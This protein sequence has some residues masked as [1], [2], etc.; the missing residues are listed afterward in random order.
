ML[1]ATLTA[2]V[3]AKRHQACAGEAVALENVATRLIRSACG[4]AAALLGLSFSADGAS[5]Q[6][7]STFPL[8]RGAV[9]QLGGSSYQDVLTRPRPEYDPIGIHVRSFFVMPS[10][11]SKLLFDDNVF[12]AGSSK[13]SDWTLQTRPELLVR[14]DWSNHSLQMQFS[15][16]NFTHRTF[17]EEDH[18]DYSA[19]IDG[20]LD[21]LRTLNVTGAAAY[22]HATIERGTDDDL[23]GDVDQPIT[24]DQVEL[25]GFVNGAFSRLFASVGAKLRAS[26]YND[27]LIG[28]TEFDQDY[29][30]GT[31]T[32]GIS[33]LGYQL[34]PMTGIFVQGTY[35]VRRFRDSFYDS[36]GLRAVAGLAFE[37][38]R[39]IRGEVY[40]GYLQQ[41][42]AS[43][44][45]DDLMTWTYGARL[46]W[47]PTPLI[48]VSL[49]GKREAGQ[50][51]FSSGS[52]VIEN[53]ANLRVDYEFRRNVI[54]SG[55][56]GYQVEDYQAS[57][58]DTS[59]RFGGEAR[60]FVNRYFSVGIEG[61]HTRFESDSVEDYQRNRVGI[62]GR[63]QY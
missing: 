42:F 48:T 41:D 28:G 2:S 4:I 13:E 49:E 23:L 63:F 60:Y 38:S 58:T 44:M 26:D 57:R 56:A 25:E 11:T 31:V 17:S 27:S 39:L 30:D 12:A 3:S 20:R 55:M 51:S 19:A 21:V 33:R 47:Q 40:G 34:T 37:A 29:R 24:F 9:D 36:E 53:D 14:S 6:W 62:S 43:P 22:K 32:E 59:L 61:D 52:S 10:V 54:L 15:A 8:R 5:A 35:N 16:E 7:E 46:G 50:S 1:A 45:L 18:T